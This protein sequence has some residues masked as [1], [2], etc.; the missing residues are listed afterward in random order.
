[1]FR[2]FMAGFGFVHSCMISWLNRIRGATVDDA[3]L[4]DR[5]PCTLMPLNLDPLVV[6][7]VTQ[8]DR[9]L[10]RSC[11]NPWG[12]QRYTSTDRSHSN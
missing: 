4:H 3:S 6:V 7:L 5:D 12:E 9:D 11:I 8:I 10:G 2:N 1:M